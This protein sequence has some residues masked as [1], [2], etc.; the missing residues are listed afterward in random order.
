MKLVKFSLF[1]PLLV[2]AVLGL[3]VC[4]VKAAPVFDGFDGDLASWN[5]AGD[6]AIQ[7]LGGNNRVVLT[8]SLSSEGDDAV[9][10]GLLNVSGSD[11]LSGGGLLE[12]AAGLAAGALDVDVVNQAT[13]GSV[14][15]RTFTVNAGDVLSFD[16]QLM[17][18][19]EAFGGAGG[20]DYAFLTINGVLVTLGTAS[21]A[22]VAGT[23]PYLYQTGLTRY[24]H[25][26]TGSGNVTVAFGVTDV[27]DYSATTSL[28]LDNV[29]VVPEP[30]AI[31]LMG[32]G[33]LGLVGFGY[34][35]RRRAAIQ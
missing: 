17:T 34:I 4:S 19:D 31:L 13:E 20:L 33:A 22:N 8:T 23:A 21:D 26:F 24:E 29:T 2:T 3:G 1:R 16:W 7:N 30:S 9:D 18:R 12:A 32:M 10:A 11:P 28:I 14:L 35:R 6:V 15:W 25:V 27:G 5:P